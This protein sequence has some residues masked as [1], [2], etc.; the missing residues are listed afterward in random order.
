[1]ESGLVC[2]KRP[3]CIVSMSRREFVSLDVTIKLNLDYIHSNSIVPFVSSSV[4]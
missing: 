1:M 2:N 3:V 4:V